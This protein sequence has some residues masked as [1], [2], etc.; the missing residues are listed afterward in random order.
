MARLP[1]LTIADQ[2]H[3]VVQSGNNGMVIFMDAQDH[4]TLLDLLRDQAPRWQVQVHA[5][6]LMPSRF[7]LLLTPRTAEGLPKL[8]QALGRAYVRYFNDR[9][10]R[11]GT[12]WEGRYRGTVI[13]PDWLLACMV[14]MDT[15]PVH[16]GLVAQAGDWP[17]SSH[18]HNAGLAS[19]GWIQPHAVFWTLG[20]TPFAR[21]AAYV[22]AVNQGLSADDRERIDEAAMRGWALGSADFLEKLQQKTKRRL[23]RQRAGRPAS[24]PAGQGQELKQA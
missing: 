15:C 16:A 12:L 21:D 23:T 20:N 10:G 8:M 7:H 1:R 3:H 9:H 11:S 18:A 13:E 6:L 17:W 4:E 14:F 19:N 22:Q 5:Y 2:P 24:Q